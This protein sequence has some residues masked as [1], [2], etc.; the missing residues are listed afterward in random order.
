MT[1]KRDEAGEVGEPRATYRA[2]RRALSRKDREAALA[3]IDRFRK[4]Y[5]QPQEGW[6][7][8]AVLRRM[9]YSE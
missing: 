7:S 1:S 5:G 4:R 2:R 3:E 9:R 8:V 6:D